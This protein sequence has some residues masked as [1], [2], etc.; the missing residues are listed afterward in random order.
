MQCCSPG[1]HQNSLILHS[2]AADQN[3]AQNRKGRSWREVW[4]GDTANP[5]SVNVYQL[6]RTTLVT[7]LS[8]GC[9]V[10]GLKHQGSWQ[11]PTNTEMRGGRQLPSRSC[12]FV[13]KRHCRAGEEQQYE[14]GTPP[15]RASASTSTCSRPP[16]QIPRT[17]KPSSQLRRPPSKFTPYSSCL[18]KQLVRSHSRTSASLMT[19]S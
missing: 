13:S 3:R 5:Q 12:R 2:K 15:R 17:G 16:A 19:A 6:R 9:S 7:T 14:M 1:T 8:L 4:T 18:Q 11:S 10:S